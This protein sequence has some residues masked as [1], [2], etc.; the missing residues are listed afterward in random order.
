MPKNRRKQG[1][2]LITAQEIASF[3]FCPESWRLQYGVGLPSANRAAMKMGDR[4]HARK[5]VAEEVA[6]GLLT[7]GRVLA[8]VALLVLLLL[9]LRWWL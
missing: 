3:A 5:A 8:V 2:D 6:G 9:V 1:N 4:H 7:L